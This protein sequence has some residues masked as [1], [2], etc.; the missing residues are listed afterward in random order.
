MLEPLSPLMVR[1][2]ASLKLSVTDLG[3]ND[4]FQKSL[5]VIISSSSQQQSNDK[6]SDYLVVP[7]EQESYLSHLNMLKALTIN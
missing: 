1:V 5:L 6:L 7:T 3:S 2:E 4:E